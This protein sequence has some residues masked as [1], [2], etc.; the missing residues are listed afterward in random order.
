MEADLLSSKGS[1]AAKA[2]E[3]FD[4]VIAISEK[5]GSL[6][7]TASANELAGEFYLKIGAETSS[8]HYFTEAY[9]LCKKW[10]AVAKADHLKE[11]RQSYIQRTS[12]FFFAAEYC[13]IV[14]MLLWYPILTVL[15][16]PYWRT[17]IF[18]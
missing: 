17:K 18:P 5:A 11:L 10:G 1:K 4:L 14:S 3:A 9:H 2:K 7:D 6:Q 8:R 13:P 15:E 16:T 12:V